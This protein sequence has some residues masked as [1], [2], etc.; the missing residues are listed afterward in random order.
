MLR[1]FEGG[2]LGLCG[3]FGGV[4]LIDRV[5][6]VD[7]LIHVDTREDRLAALYGHVERQDAERR[8]VLIGRAVGGADLLKDLRH[9]RRHEG[10]QQSSRD[11]DTLEQVVENGCEARL[12]ALVLSED[13][14]GGLVDIFVGSR[15]ELED[16]FER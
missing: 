6:R 10:R 4:V 7:L 2:R 16:L 9:S 1:Q 8:G 5:E 3:L 11:A 15:D 12:L 14:R 13:P